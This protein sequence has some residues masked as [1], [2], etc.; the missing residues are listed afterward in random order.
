[1]NRVIDQTAKERRCQLR[2]ESGGKRSGKP[3]PFAVKRGIDHGSF[4][5]LRRFL[6]FNR[7]LET[8]RV[9]SQPDSH[10]W[11]NNHVGVLDV[12]QT[13]GHCAASEGGPQTGD[14]GTMRSL[15]SAISK[16]QARFDH[17]SP[18]SS[19]L[20]P[21]FGRG[22]MTKRFGSTSRTPT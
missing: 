6:C 20:G 17:G 22:A 8:A 16:T 7:P 1:L 18:R 21:T 13:V 12:D 4:L 11:I 3:P 10:P 9:N 2:H 14:R 19:S 15:G 5:H